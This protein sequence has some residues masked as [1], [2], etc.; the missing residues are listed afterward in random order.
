VSILPDDPWWQVF[1]ALETWV[2]C[3]PDLHP[4]RFQDGR[5]GLAAHPDAE[6][7]LVFAALSGEKAC[8]VEVAAAWRQHAD[9]LRVL[10]LGPRGPSDTVNISW[11]DIQ[12]F[13]SRP[14]SKYGRPSGL[15]RRG[16]V[17][18]QPMRPG[19]PAQPGPPMRPG[20]PTQ[21]GP[22]MRPRPPAQPGPPMRPRP[23]VQPGPAV[24]PG[25]A[26]SPRFPPT[27]AGHGTGEPERVRAERLEMLL[28]LALGPAFQMLLSGLVAA[29]WSDGGAR[30]SDRP[31]HR[32]ALEAALTGRLAAAVAPWLGISPDRV[33]ARLHEGTGWGRLELTGSGLRASLPAG[34]LATVWAGGLAVV[35]GHLVVAVQRAA[36]PEATVL[37][38]PEPGGGPVVL[39][40]RADEDASCA[41]DRAHW[42]VTDRWAPGASHGRA[43]PSG[44]EAGRP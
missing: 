4:V 41:R 33:D 43:G 27:F 21:P 23:P 38:V 14:V 35:D 2:P 26:G 22:P 20:P 9:D 32:P 39:N 8:C 17:H 7:E 19:P 44:G 5:L 10:A 37:A 18:S 29:A 16:G 13:R 36:W 40:I 1:P 25:P 34:W 15:T 42:E 11:D 30:A 12:D 6:G 3:G 24:R 28:L 31:R